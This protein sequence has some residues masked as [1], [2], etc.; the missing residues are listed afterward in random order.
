[1]V[2]VKSSDTE[3][4]SRR[5]QA[6]IVAERTAHLEPEQQDAVRWIHSVYHDENLSLDDLGRRVGYDK[7]TLSQVFQGTYKGKLDRVVEAIEAYR[8]KHAEQAKV[9]EEFRLPFIE[10][11]DS[12]EISRIA[13]LARRFRRFAVAMGDSQIGKSR[14][15]E[16]LRDSDRSGNTVFV[17]VPPGAR[18]AEFVVILCK[19]IHQPYGRNTASLWQ[20]ILN[21]FKARP[22][23]LLIVDEVARC[24]GSKTYGGG[25]F[26]IIERVRWLH[27]QARVGV[28]L[29]ATPTLKDALQDDMHR[30]WG[31]QLDR[32]TV[33]E[34]RLAD[35]PSLQSLAMYAAHY[36]LEPA[37]GAARIVE[38]RIIATQGKG[39]WLTFLALG[40]T[41]AKN[42]G[43]P[44][45][46]AH[47]IEAVASV[48]EYASDERALRNSD[49]ETKLMRAARK[50]RGRTVAVVGKVVAS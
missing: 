7:A 32:R 39:V 36:G 19:A 33:W 42:A 31:E 15:G 28:M 46:W 14:N 12:Q 38:R 2:A 23:S 40:N 26:R 34:I 5:V 3:V 20:V 1:M 22:G 25:S 35:V 43:V 41:N 17:E 48:K 10:D 4:S 24:G 44:M 29:F 37:A 47:V 8:V 16:Q 6:Y 21:W 18:E 45:E 11:E 50:G 9:N 13:E 30:K 27:D 49:E